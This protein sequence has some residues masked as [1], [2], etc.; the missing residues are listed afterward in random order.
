MAARQN[1]H[2]AEVESA[3]AR[4]LDQFEELRMDLTNEQLIAEAIEV[5]HAGISDKSLRRYEDHLVHFGQYLASAHGRT[6]YTA[7]RKHVRLFM[8]HLERE[9]GQKP[10]RSRIPCEWCRVRGYSDGKEGRGWSA[11]Y[12][13]SYLCAVKFAY[14]HFQAEENLP[15]HNPAV[16]ETSPKVIYKRGY[17]LS[18]EEVR[19]LLHGEGT[20]KARLLAYWMLY[21][22]SRRATFSDARWPDIDLDA[23]TWTVIGKGGKVEVFALAPPL[24]REFRAYRRWQLSEA[25][26]NPAMRD[27][28]AS[29]ETAYVLLTK[30]GKGTHPNT[31]GKMLKRHAARNGVGV[32]Q[33]EKAWDM[34]KGVTSLVSPHAMRRTWATLALNDEDEPQSIDVVQEVLNH[35]PPRVGGRMVSGVVH[36][37]EMPQELYRPG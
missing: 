17:S 30:N 5:N 36:A 4:F 21:A 37:G 22:P 35:T 16:L 10:H 19:Q 32:Q 12:R 23:A 18:K 28:L 8:N 34:P 9:G 7:Q 25:Q 26:R 11:S 33:V 13:K 31:V 6:F 14:R 29:P 27:A 1:V 2:L 3:P 24:V 20:P 15:D